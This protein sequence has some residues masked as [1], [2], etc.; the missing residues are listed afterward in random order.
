M[1]G[2]SLPYLLDAVLMAAVLLFS[3]IVHEVAHGYVALLNGDPTAK[4]SGRLTLN[5][6]PHLDPIGTV[7]LPLLLL[8]TGSRILFGWARPVPVNPLNFRHYMWGEISV[9][10]AGPLSNLALAVV[11]A[12]LLRLGG[13]NLGLAKLAYYGVSI[14]IFLALFNLI[15]IPP[16]DG[17]HVV[18]AIL[19]RELN[20]LYQYLEPVGF[21]LILFLFYTGLMGMVLMPIYWRIARLLLFG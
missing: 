15:P 1:P 10:A 5:P 4:L 14:N 13:G 18:A 3:I 19:P 12:L 7:F 9:S 16:L 20:R 6:G 17:S 21:I 2:L 11:F 8:L